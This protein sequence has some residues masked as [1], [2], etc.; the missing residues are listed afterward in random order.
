MQFK[1]S[2]N[3]FLKSLNL[4]SRAASTNTPLPALSGIK[5]E[6]NDESVILTASDSNISIKSTLLKSDTKNE[7]TITEKGICVVDFRYIL[8]IARKINGNYISLEIMDGT[9]IKIEGGSSEFKLNGIPSD[10][11]PEISFNLSDKKIKFK[12]KM[13]NDIVEQTSFA[14]SDKETKPALTGVNLIAKNKVLHAN[15]TDSYRLASKNIELDEEFEFNITIPSKHLVDVTRSIQD[16]SEVEISIDN[17]KIAFI[18]GNN[19][20]QTRLIEDLYPDTSRLVPPSFAQTLIVNSK[21]ILSAID[22]TSFIKSDGK[23]VVKM[24]INSESMTITSSSQEIGSSFETISIIEYTGNPLNISCSGKYLNDAIK[25]LKSEEIV[26][27]FNGDIKP[28]VLTKKDDDSI[29]QLISPVRTY[30]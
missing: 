3:E 28:I 12:T 22:R 5:I 10:E 9:L 13:L 24:S 6:V 29:L 23:N 7:L 8:E 30:N 21:D 19:I 2:K 27:K 26:M 16:E 4:V 20:I 18:F 11:Y 25:A 15:A 14:C 1:I 17:Q